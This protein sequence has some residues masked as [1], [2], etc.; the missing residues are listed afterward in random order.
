[1]QRISP[2]KKERT[3]NNQKP[4]LLTREAGK[5]TPKTVISSTNTKKPKTQ[6]TQKP[7]TLIP[8]SQVPSHSLALESVCNWSRIVQRGFM[9]VRKRPSHSLPPVVPT[10]KSQPQVG[11]DTPSSVA[12]PLSLWSHSRSRSRW[13]AQRVQSN[14]IWARVSGTPHPSHR[15]D[16]RWPNRCKYTPVGK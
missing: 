12:W 5:N 9:A 4:N 3:Q 11:R 16:E 2:K 14:S 13:N 7:T 10:R 8:N 15:G 1:M 6:K